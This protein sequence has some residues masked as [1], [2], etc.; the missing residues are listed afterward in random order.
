[1]I[2]GKKSAAQ[3]LKDMLDIFVSTKK[4]LLAILDLNKEEKDK[5]TAD[6]KVKEEEFK[7]QKS[8]YEADMRK[9]DEL[10]LEVKTAL[11]GFKH[12][13]LTKDDDHSY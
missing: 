11:E 7:V 13:V 3:E 12:I 9:A 8:N 5:A 10:D 4:K 1:M 6:F 2:F